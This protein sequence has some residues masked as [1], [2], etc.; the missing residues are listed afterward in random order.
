MELRHLRYFLAVADEL[1]FTRAARSL[2]ISQPALSRQIK[3]LEEHLGVELLIRN[4]G[5][6]A[7]SPAGA[8]FV[9]RAQVVLSTVADAELAVREFAACR[10]S[11]IDI[12]YM[13]AVFGSFLSS[14]MRIFRQTHD[15]VSLQLHDLPPGRQVEEL[16]AG[17]LD[18][19]LVGRACPMLEN[20]FDLFSI[21]KLPVVVALP[22]E[23]RL[24]GRKSIKVAEL[25]E[26]SFIRLSE[27]AFPER[28]A[29]V[30]EICEKG[31]FEPKRGPLADTLATALG[32]VC[33]E[34]GVLLVPSE[35]ES[36]APRNLAFVPLRE[37]KTYI[38]FYAIVQR[39]EKRAAVRVF[40]QECRRQA[41]GE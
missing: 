36:V 38:H 20:E 3:D 19:A 41:M 4:T 8:A 13:P 37:P 5:A 7:L 34:Q 39:D 15:Q 14:A 26:E 32:L 10:E 18:I 31:G 9:T 22:S 16:R 6:V 40:L 11:R 29:F 17:R 24:A 30:R 27:S 35:V 23:H 33:G 28:N 12:G 2:R 1:N 25:A 21:H